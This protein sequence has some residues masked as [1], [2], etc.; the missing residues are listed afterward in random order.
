[1]V[2]TTFKLSQTIGG[3]IQI[4]SAKMSLVIACRKDLAKITAKMTG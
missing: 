1:M 4:P 3:G 2:K